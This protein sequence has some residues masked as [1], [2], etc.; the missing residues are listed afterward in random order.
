MESFAG[1]V[2]DYLLHAAQTGREVIAVPPFV[3][4]IDPSTDLRYLN[5]AIP[6]EREAAAADTEVDGGSHPSDGHR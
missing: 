2:Q 6:A 5:Y 1:R 3:V 4:T